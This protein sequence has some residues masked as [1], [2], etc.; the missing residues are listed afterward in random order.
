[1]RDGIHFLVNETL[2][3]ASL[4]G[5]PLVTRMIGTDSLGLW[6]AQWPFADQVLAS[7]LVFDLGIT[8]AHAASHRELHRLHHRKEPGRGDVN[9]GL[10]T[11]LGDR[12]L[13]T[14]D[15]DLEERL[16]GGD[17]GIWGPA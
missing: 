1:M 5:L 6:P 9:F 14:L 3:V 13:G 8:F 15:D 12:I 4:A 16:G 17:L 10:F 7:L 11:T 2:I